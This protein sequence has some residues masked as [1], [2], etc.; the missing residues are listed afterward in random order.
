MA[1]EGQRQTYLEETYQTMLNPRTVSVEP[2][3]CDDDD[4]LGVPTISKHFRIHEC[5]TI[6]LEGLLTGDQTLVYPYQGGLLPRQKPGW[7]LLVERDLC[8]FTISS[9][10]LKLC[11]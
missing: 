5:R 2:S 9:R 11:I 4:T 6:S 10:S 7:R 1:G 3:D 8:P